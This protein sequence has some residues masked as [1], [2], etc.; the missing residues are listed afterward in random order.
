MPLTHP[1][2]LP[3]P[4]TFTERHRVTTALVVLGYLVL[5]GAS[6]GSLIGSLLAQ[7]VNAFLDQPV[8]THGGP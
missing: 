6:T 4:V 3:Q 7:V 5:L 8:F 2:R 1:T